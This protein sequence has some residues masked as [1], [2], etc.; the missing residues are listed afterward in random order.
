MHSHLQE[1]LWANTKKHVH[2]DLQKSRI[3]NDDDD[4]TSI[5][6][7]IEECFIDPFSENRLVCLSNGILAT[8]KL[9][10]KLFNDF[11]LGTERMEHRFINEQCVLRNLK[12][13]SILLC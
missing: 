8:E 10:S 11:T 3:R 9:V 6:S 5:L 2:T 13:F 4:V 12:I 7:I 1:F